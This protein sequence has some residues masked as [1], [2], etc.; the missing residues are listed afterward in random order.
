MCS[1]SIN[2]VLEIQECTWNIMI[3]FQNFMIGSKRFWQDKNRF[4][5]QWQVEYHFNLGWLYDCQYFPFKYKFRQNKQYPKWPS[6]TK[7]NKFVWKIDVDEKLRT[8]NLP[9]QKP[10]QNATHLD[11]SMMKQGHICFLKHHLCMVDG[12]PWLL[13]CQIVSSVKIEPL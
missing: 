12:H 6:T 11:P 10:C 13:K 3:R 8:K 9:N 2:W 5:K 7:R 1:R 4:W